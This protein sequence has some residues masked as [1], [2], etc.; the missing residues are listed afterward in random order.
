M[1]GIVGVITPESK[2]SPPL[3]ALE[4]HQ[5]LLTLQ[6]RG[7]DAAG[8]LAYD[9]G[10]Q[11][12]SFHKGPG[13]ISQLF[14][15]R[16]LERV[17]GHMAIGHTRYTTLGSDDHQN[18]QPLVTGHPL[19][20]GMVHNGN[21]LNYHQ[22]TSKL[23]Q[24]EEQHFLSSSDLELILN[25]WSG[26][27]TQQKTSGKSNY[28]EC[29][30]AAVK[31]IFQ[32]VEGAYSTIGLLAGRGLFAFRDP[33]GIRPLVLG[34]K[35][36]D[37]NQSWAVASESTAL[38][39]TGHQLVRSINP[40]ELLFITQQGELHSFDLAPTPKPPPSHCMFEWVYFSSAN[41]TCEDRSIYDT[42]FRL[43]EALAT[44]SLQLIKQGKISPD[45]VIPIPDTSRTAAVALAHQ[46]EL[47]YREGLLKNRYTQRSFILPG[48]QERERA[49]EQKLS[50]IPSEI[51]GKSILLV[52]DSVVRGTTSKRILNLLR[53]YGAKEIYLAVAC[54]PIKHPC[55]YGIDFPSSSELIA[56]DRSEGEIAKM[57]GAD[58]VIYLNESELS[59]AITLPHLC[60]ACLNGNYPTSIE[61]AV[62]F[63]RQRELSRDE[64]C[65]S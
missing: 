24:E 49:I 4:C 52:D 14:D 10:Q 6:H 16:E 33:K 44:K 18:L 36:V 42:R 30:Q 15:Q 53:T 8:I 64:S 9:F 7:Q 57:I 12:F 28:L 45:V 48:Q 3:A 65:E 29:S 23:R 43:G 55:Y 21:I 46:L 35:E 25:L 34:Q 39:F 61:P 17:K 60:L 1:C 31:K 2:N 11:S 13:L 37:G 19:G 38:T 27:Y 5:A 54:P 20:V 41:S 51:E 40:G 22:V 32:T 50:P 62:E 26:G 63:T 59:K 56:A 47:P 58:R